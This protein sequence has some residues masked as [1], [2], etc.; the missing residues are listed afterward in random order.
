MSAPE[1][2]GWESRTPGNCADLRKHLADFE[3]G[4]LRDQA[5]ALLDART[6]IEQRSWRPA[7][8]AMPLRIVVPAIG[9]PQRDVAQAR[10]DAERRGATKGE[11][12]CRD[13]DA[14]GVT[15]LRSSVTEPQEWT[16]DRGREGFVCGFEGRVLCA[17]DELVR[18]QQEQCG[19]NAKP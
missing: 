19:S 18:T 8:N 3:S 10:T 14:A 5:R 16:C 12:M 17:Q 4:A 1:A 11:Q 6:V 13:V 2:I 9:T 15:R 7:A